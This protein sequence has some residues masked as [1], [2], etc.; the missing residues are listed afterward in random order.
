MNKNN[1]TVSNDNVE[2]IKCYIEQTN[3]IISNLKDDNDI[4]IIFKKYADDLRE[5]SN[6]VRNLKKKTTYGGN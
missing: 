1:F 3:S 4:N 2:E 5:Y 6:E